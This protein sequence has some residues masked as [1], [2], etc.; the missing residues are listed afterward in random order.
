MPGREGAGL[1]CTQLAWSSVVLCCAVPRLPVPSAQPSRLCTVVWYRPKQRCIA[2]VCPPCPAGTVPT[3]DAA[4]AAVEKIR[5][6][7]GDMGSRAKM[8][9]TVGH[10]TGGCRCSWLGRQPGEPARVEGWTAML[11]MP[12][13]QALSYPP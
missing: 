12:A 2:S 11:Q 8:H 13:C 1:G 6:Y 3:F 9:V 5:F 10:T 7:A 4:V